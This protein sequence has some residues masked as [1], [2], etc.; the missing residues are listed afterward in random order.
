LKKILESQI[1]KDD[2]FIDITLPGIKP[3]QGGY[4]PIESVSREIENIFLRMGYSIMD[5][6]E[7]ED[8]WYNFEALNMLPDHPARD[9][10][11]TFYLQDGLVLRTHTSPVQIRTMENQDPPVRI[12]CP[13]KT[14]R[15]D[16]D[17]THTPNFFQIEG[18]M[19]D[20]GVT[21]AD[22]RG[23]ID[24]FCKQLFEV[25]TI[26]RFRPSYFPFVEPGAEVDIRCIICGG[27]GCRTCK[28]T[29]WL[30][31]MGAGMVH[32]K[33]LDNV[34]YDSELYTGFAFGMGIDRIT[35]L[36]YGIDDTRLFYES[37]L[38]FLKQFRGI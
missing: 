34:G 20:I 35:M 36:K 29:G 38:R 30:E 2:L 17:I 1:V 14:F 8:D 15:V 19:I 10:H 37:N 24:L 7:A 18:L 33:V 28:R 6:P 26:T 27:K 4:H 16:W 9:M 23:T 12:I 32:K 3:V 5:G 25:D 22:L 13:G 11:D 21:F 31:I